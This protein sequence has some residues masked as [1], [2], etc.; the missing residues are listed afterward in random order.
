MF[1]YLPW[2][3]SHKTCHWP[4]RAIFRW[5]SWEGESLPYIYDFSQSI[6]FMFKIMSDVLLPRHTMPGRD[7]SM[8]LTSL[9]ITHH[10][11][12]LYIGSTCFLQSSLRKT[13]SVFPTRSLSWIYCLY[14]KLEST[15]IQSFNMYLLKA[16]TFMK[17]LC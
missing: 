12:Q 4:L 10:S 3:V 13:F 6:S 14:P 11:E 5:S 15:F 2:R 1:S 16:S 9:P 17:A 7:S 8:W